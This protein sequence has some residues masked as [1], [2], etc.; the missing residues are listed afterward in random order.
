MVFFDGYGWNREKF[1]GYSRM[2][3]ELNAYARARGIKLLFAGYGANYGRIVRPEHNVGKVW[4]NRDHYPDGPIYSCFGENRPGRGI[5]GTCRGNDELNRLKAAEMADFVRSVEPGALY[6]HHEDRG[7][8]D[9][10]ID[11]HLT[12]YEL[13]VTW[14]KRCFRCREKWPN[15][16]LITKDGG[17]G[18]VA[19]GY[20]ELL[21]AIRSVK[22]A[23]S[24]YDAA[25]DCTVMFLSPGYNPFPT[26]P[27]DWEN[28]LIFWEN[29]VSLLPDDENF[30]IGFREVFPQQGTDVRWLDA[31]RQRLG[32]QGLN[33]RT[34]LFFLGGADLYSRDSFNYPFAG[35]AAMNGIFKGAETI[36]NFSGAGFQEPLQLFNAEYSWNVDAPGHVIPTRY[37]ETRSTWRALMNNRNLPPEITGSSGFLAEAFRQLYGDDAGAKMHRI[38]KFYRTQRRMEV[39]GRDRPD[40]HGHPLRPDGGPG[41]RK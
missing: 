24:G 8:G 4:Y 6:I 40:D 10:N 3:R 7:I 5:V 41:L 15:D 11:Y 17:A 1:P 30:E 18:G 12:N 36:Y 38:F 2:M 27:T 28:H 21:R 9:P 26:Q 22:N 31:Y 23:D 20:S 33:N 19:H 39:A 32:S 29:V 25:R 13:W 14:K 16:S 34:F 35:T 37:E